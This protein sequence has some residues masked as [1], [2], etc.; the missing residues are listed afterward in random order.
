MADL[1]SSA[2]TILRSAVEEEDTGHEVK[3]LMAKVTIAS[4]GTATNKILAT[5][6]GLTTIYSATPFVK[7]DDTLVYVVAPA[8]DGSFL[9][10]VDGDNATAANQTAPADKSG[11]FYTTIR[12]V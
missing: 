7:S 5:A 11:T 9:L 3:S 6:F 10:L 8:A 4:M 2:V 1:A 12:G